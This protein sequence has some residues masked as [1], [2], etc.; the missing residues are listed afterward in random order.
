MQ[1]NHFSVGLVTNHACIIYEKWN[2]LKFKSL[3]KMCNFFFQM[4]SIFSFLIGLFKIVAL[5][6]QNEAF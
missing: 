5:L 2:L 6:S 1:K 3:P 4:K